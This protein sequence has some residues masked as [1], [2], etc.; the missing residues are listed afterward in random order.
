[1]N[2]WFVKSL[3]ETEGIISNKALPYIL[4]WL[5]ASTWALNLT[6]QLSNFMHAV[7]LYPLEGFGE[8]VYLFLDL[9]FVIWHKGLLHL[10]HKADSDQFSISQALVREYIGSEGSINASLWLLWSLAKCWCQKHSKNSLTQLNTSS[11][12]RLEP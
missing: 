12:V 10:F 11:E 3:F 5:F 7:T 8:F 9:I 1:M 2:L 6:F 4:K